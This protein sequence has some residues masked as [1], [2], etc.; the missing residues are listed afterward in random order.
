MRVLYLEVADNLAT[1]SFLIALG[2]F[3]ARRGHETIIIPDNGSNFIIGES[4]LTVIGK[5]LDNKRVTQHLNSKNIT[6]K[7]NPPQAH[8]CVVHGNH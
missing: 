8:G 2:W 3:I 6:C 1:E 7:F 5:E 4:K